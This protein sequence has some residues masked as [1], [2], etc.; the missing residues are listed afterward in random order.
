MGNMIVNFAG[1]EFRNPVVTASGTFGFGHEYAQFY[2][3]SALG[4]ITVKG[5]TF[6]GRDGNTPPRIAETAMGML[7]SVGLQNPGIKKFIEVE[8]PY[9]RTLDTNIIANIAG[10]SI[11]QFGEMAAMISD[12]CGVHMLELN[13][14]C[15][16]VSDGGMLFGTSATAIAS[17]TREVRK[18]TKIPFM[19][20]LTPN[21]TDITEMAR[22]AEGEGADGIS[23]INTLLGMKIDVET[24][25]PVLY[26]NTGGLS[27]PAVLPVAV[28]MVWQVRNAVKIP[29]LGMGGIYNGEDAVE[30]L[31][32]GADLVGVGSANITYP[33]APLTVLNGLSSY[34]EAHNISSVTEL[35]GKVELN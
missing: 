8:L 30:M 14:S 28:R 23:L 20:K 1:V 17:V 22:A 5:L 24:R 7:N 2:D 10:D 21:V 26:N 31:L 27:G 4:G 35:S 16:N 33:M 19:V 29:I 6:N 9:L 32:A 34:M 25:K 3:L 12:A 18:R 13:V 15:P 11:E